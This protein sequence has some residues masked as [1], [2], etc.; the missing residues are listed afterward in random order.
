L[1]AIE[2]IG[3]SYPEFDACSC[4]RQPD[5]VAGRLVHA[6]H[7]LVAAPAQHPAAGARA[8]AEVRHAAGR[9]GLPDHAA[10]LGQGFRE[11]AI[12]FVIVTSDSYD[13]LARVSQQILA[14]MA[15]NPASCSPTAT[16]G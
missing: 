3:M 13:N 1:Q 10:S 16:C 12:N 15:K 8:A 5:G 7:R 9:G 11:R 14:E 6:H 4:H 2:R